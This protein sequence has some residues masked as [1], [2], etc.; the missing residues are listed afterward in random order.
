MRT[1][2]GSGPGAPST[3]GRNRSGTRPLRSVRRQR[4]SWVVGQLMRSNASNARSRAS[5]THAGSSKRAESASTAPRVSSVASV[6]WSATRLSDRALHLQFDE[7][8]ELNGVLQRQLLHD[9]LDE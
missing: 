5:R 4:A 6:I 9:R 8:V 1:A 3:N 2:A 7:T